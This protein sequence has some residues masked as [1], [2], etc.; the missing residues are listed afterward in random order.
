M[1][2]DLPWDTLIARARTELASRTALCDR[3][4]GLGEAAWSLDLESGRIRFEAA[5]KPRAIAPA[6][7][8]GTH[9]PVTGSWLWGW[10]HPSVP[11][12][13]RRAAARLRALGAQRGIAPFTDRQVPASDDEAWT[14]TALAALLDGAEGAYAAPT[15]RA[16]IFLVF[17]PVTLGP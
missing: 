13:L 2:T 1:S 11:E 10:D 6:Q 16:R 4:F 12:P 7:I 8:I 3:L 5:G 17:G 15:D 14:W 9:D